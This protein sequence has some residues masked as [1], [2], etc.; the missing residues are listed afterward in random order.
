MNILVLTPTGNSFNSLRPEAEIY[1]SLSKAG[2][3]ITVMT[4]KDGKYTSRY[5]ENNI[6]V[7]DASHKEKI[8]LKTIKKVREI[9]KNKSI[10]IVYA[11]S[12]RTIPNAA[13]ACIGTKAKLVAYRG[14]TGGLY[15]HDPTSYLN[16]LHPR[17]NG[18]ICVSEA[19]N[20]HVS[21]QVFSTSSKKIITIHKGHDVNWYNQHPLNL[22]EFGTN[23]KNFNIA[24]VANV[25]AHKGLIYAI[26]AAHDLA[27]IKELHILLIGSKISEE[28]YLSLIQNSGMKER[29]HVTGYRHDVPEILAACDLLIHPS[30]RKEGLPRVVLESI[31][32]GTPVIASANEGSMEII[33]DGYNGYIVPIKDSKAIADRVRELYNSPE[34][35]KMLSDNCIKKIENEMSHKTTVKKYIK[36]FE[37]LIES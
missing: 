4:S 7:V 6:E 10:D 27:D 14:T 17:V 28:P 11:T 9:I 26:K 15:R 1:I 22:E 18:V 24:F 19:I 33:D 29:I 21:K 2:H 23:T 20:R 8:S 25:R 12:S 36:Y 32:S 30:I 34:K 16:I 13:F 5:L 3:N 35:L 37:S 31:A